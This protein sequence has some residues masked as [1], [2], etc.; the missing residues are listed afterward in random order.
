MK[1]KI[2]SCKIKILVCCHKQCALPPN[3]D[4]LFLPIQVGAAISDVDFGM[5]RDDMVNG[6]PCDNISAKN[7]NYCELTAIYWAWKNLRK[8]YPNVE[9][10]GLNHYRRYFDFDKNIAFDYQNCKKESDIKFY[11]IKFGKLSSILHNY[12]GI[13]SKPRLYPYSVEHDYGICHMS[14]DFRVLE[15]VVL[16]LY[17]SFKKDFEMSLKCSRVLSHFNMFILKIKDFEN[18]C[19]WLFKILEECEKR[20]PYQVYNNV[21]GRIFGYMAE[22][23]L[24]VYI[25]HKKMDVK[26]LPIYFFSERKNNMFFSRFCKHFRLLIS[27]WFQYPICIHI[28]WFIKR[29]VL[30]QESYEKLKTKLKKSNSYS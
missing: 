21:Q 23:L 29:N 24:N 18:Y 19:E 5:Q 27:W 6:K 9:Y 17:P 22:R 8:I 10:V 11:K 30:S 13:I 2:D 15:K 7:K 16:E 4:G 14:E 1:N 26:K 12:C 28:K 25:F 20:I 3:P